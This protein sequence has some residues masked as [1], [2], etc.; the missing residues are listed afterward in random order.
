MHVEL[1][2]TFLGDGV[3]HQDVQGFVGIEETLSEHIKTSYLQ[4]VVH[5]DVG[6]YYISSALPKLALLFVIEL[7]EHIS[8]QLSF[9]MLANKA[10]DLC[11]PQGM[12]HRVFLYELLVSDR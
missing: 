7:S 4:I 1:V 12:L 10:S 8:E 3:A 5:L 6:T 9:N 2:C 11:G